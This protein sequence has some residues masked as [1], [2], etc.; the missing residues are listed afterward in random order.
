MRLKMQGEARSDR[1]L[2]VI[3]RK[4]R[5]ILNMFGA[6]RNIP[7]CG[8]SWSYLNLEAVL[9]FDFMKFGWKKGQLGSSEMVP[10]RRD[11]GSK[12]RK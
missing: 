3:V 10:A 7:S 1:E 11:R 9:R 5:F 12:K 2:H 8:R 4:L 6:R